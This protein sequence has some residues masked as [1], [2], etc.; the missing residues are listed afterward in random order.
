MSPDK[1]LADLADELSKG[2]II[3]APLKSSDEH[4]EGWCVH[5]TKQIFIDPRVSI[6]ETLLHELIHRRWPNLTEASVRGIER[7][8]MANLTTDDVSR[9]YRLY[10]KA[11]RTRRRT[12][13]VED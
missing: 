7:H 3:E 5:A 12:V 4:I 2:G 9:W 10:N 8:L 11:K 1:R 13:K 6:V